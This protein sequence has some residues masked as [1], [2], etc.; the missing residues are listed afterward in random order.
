[1]RRG[2][3][4]RAH[5]AA[6]GEAIE[7]ASMAE[8]A[9]FHTVYVTESHLDSADG[10][11]N[12]FAVAAAMSGRLR[13]ASIGVLPAIGME[14]PLRVVEQ[15]NLLNVLTRGTSFVV[16]SDRLEPRQYAAFGLPVPRNGLLEELVQHMEDA[17]AWDFHEDGPPLEFHSGAYASTMAGRIMPAA[18][19][20][21]AFETDSEA[22]VRDAARRGWA[23]HLRI[24]D[25]E[26]T[27]TLIDSY[28]EV[29]TSAGHT[30]HVVQ[31]CL[32][33][34][35]VVVGDQ[36]VDSVSELETLGAAEVRFDVAPEAALRIV[37]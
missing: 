37:A 29:L 35:T 31:D 2:L 30:T 32:D 5:K 12:A 20:R 25:L 3:M 17:W 27:H 22:G 7:L 33:R 16:L 23:I 36:F 11:A 24:T 13:S 18:R 6:P 9:G 19:P 1:M 8:N 10:F 4:L 15:A 34:V 21:V 28:R 14:H 26:H